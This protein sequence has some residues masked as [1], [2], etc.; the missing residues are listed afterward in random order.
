MVK[1]I[2]GKSFRFTLLTER[3]LR[4]EYQADGKFE[5]R[6]TQAVIKRDFAQPKW[7]TL[8][9]QAGYVWQLETSAFHLYYRGGE[10]NGA[11][12]FLDT[13][14]NYQTHY[15]RWHFGEEP[16]KN[17]GGTAR[18]LD[19]ADG[20]VAVGP[21]ILSQ[22]GLAILDDS[23]SLVQSGDQLLP[24]KSQEIDL[25]LFIYGHDYLTALYDY[26]QLT[27]FAPL[28]PRY[29][30][31]N[32]WSRYYPY[33]QNE[34]LDLMDKFT[35]KKIPLSVA[36]FD[37]N[38]HLTRILAKYGSGWTGFTWDRQLFPQPQKML[39]QLHQQ[40]KH[41]T[42][43]LHPAAGIRATEEKYSQVAKENGIDPQTKRPVM[44]DL[45]DPQF[46]HSYFE[47]LLHPLEKMGVDFWWID[48]QQGT[49]QTKKQ[50]DPLWLLNALHYH[51]QVKQ[52]KTDAL[53]LSRYAGPGSQRYPL[54]FS[55]DTVASWKSLAFQP[56]FTA[57][58]SNI[59]YTWWS[60]DIGGHM[61]GK[62]DPE[63]ALR[64]LQLGVFSPILRLHS[65]DNPFMGKEPWNYDL[66]T[67]QAMIKFLQLR[68]KLLPYLE[69][70]NVL[71]HQAGLPLVQPLYY[72]Y[73]DEPAAYR[74]SNEYFFGSE[75]LVAPITEP[76]DSVTGLGKVKA[77]L[78]A[79]K[80]TDLFT[81]EVYL[82]P[83]IV[84]LFRFKNEY[85][86]LVKSGG[87]LVTTP[88]FMQPAAQLPEKLQIALYSGQK[89]HYVLAE[90]QQAKIAKT[91]FDWDPQRGLLTV[92]VDDPQSILPPGRS[93][94]FKLAD[95]SANNSEQKL[96]KLQNNQLYQL[97][98]TGIRPQKII[99]HQRLFK[100]LQHAKFSFELKAQLWDTI[101]KATGTS[102][103]Q[104]IGTLA[105]V[106]IA[107]PLIEVLL[108]N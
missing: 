77:Y 40:G 14:Y 80:W 28:I 7:Q 12:L 11:N 48:W 95:Q 76:A 102:L 10:F 9:N 8:H 39:E 97:Q 68:A 27:G 32:W 82:G 24:R 31:G 35:A 51:D 53:I 105:P 70:A 47:T 108:A 33:T 46:V 59:G 86:V 41:V 21:G 30:L 101:Q 107:Q 89:N 13:K 38:W 106:E 62:Y 63:L 103:I 44:F 2:T 20:P 34:Y 66:A 65:T 94:N 81:K 78:P 87:I 88:E 99:V 61:R 104:A 100:I 71:T 79:G 91:I 55:G 45:T 74:F 96:T 26:F 5:D 4:I 93:L 19:G 37:M 64:W 98:F 56:A 25:Y 36:V 17:L 1:Q 60:H 3:L 23:N 43:N 6:P 15:S 16:Q 72:H 67:E 75:F 85:P 50:A 49:A 18:T 54:G 90:H 42:L 22:N 84:S 58:A 52:K 92:K 29:A 69:T 57:T 73:P 83:A